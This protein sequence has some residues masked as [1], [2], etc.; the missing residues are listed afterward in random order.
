MKVLNCYNCGSKERTFYAEENG[1]SLVKCTGCGLLYLEERPDDKEMVHAH[2]QGRHSGLKELDVTGR[3]KPEEIPWY[4][5]VLENIF[6]GNLGNKKTWLDV[7][8]GHGEFMAAVQKYSSGKISVR[9][10][11]P[12]VFKQKSA[13]D[14]GLDVSYFDIES[15]KT[16]YDIIS[17]LNVYSHLPDP[18]AFFEM[19]KKRLNPNGEII[20]ETGDTA[21]LTA[22]EHYRPFY[23]PDH[24]SFA[25]EKIVSDILTRS[26]FEILSINKYSCLPFGPKGI[27]KEFVKACLPKYKSALPY[28]VKWKRYSQTDMFIRARMRN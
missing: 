7:G 17:L 26:G 3:F 4:L 13:R 22:K 23:L 11:E 14:R 2:Q 16:S 15:H 5:N 21:D 19:L 10:T 12:N 27:L 28:Y 6:K 9:G 8:C 1:F 24:L 25:S 18:P 20:I